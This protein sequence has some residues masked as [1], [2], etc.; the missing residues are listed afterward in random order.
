MNG[1]WYTQI[2]AVLRLEW[3]KTFFARSGL[4]IYLLALAPVLLFGGF[5]LAMIKNHR[6]GDFGEDTNVFAGIFQLFYLRLCIFFGCVGIFM[7]LFRGEM[8][9]KSLHFYFLAPIRRDVLL[10]GKYIAGLLAAIVIFS[11]STLLQIAAMY[12]HYDWN[13]MR[14]YLFE[15]GGW[16]HVLAYLG[17]TILACIGYGSVFL[18]AGVLVRNPIIPAGVILVWEAI[19]SFLPAV[20]Q[21][22][23]VIFY[24]KSLC[25]IQV[26]P[27]VGPPLSLMAINVDPMPAYVAIPGLLLLAIVV[28][29]LAALRVKRMEINY[30]TE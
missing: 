16:E 8:L 19:N 3:K 7:N 13:T 17:V 29:Y 23:S 12:A 21:K 6:P 28:L 2:M 9:N 26:P 11:T 5:S 20:L 27:Q 14:A 4:W 18:A 22:A 10:A 24:L 15:S 25:P 30:A 1:L